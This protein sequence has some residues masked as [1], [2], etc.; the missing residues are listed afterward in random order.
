MSEIVKLSE[1]DDNQVTQAIDVFI[2]GFYNVFNSVTK[3]KAKLH[4]LF[5]HSFDYEMVYTYLHD[6]DVLGFLGLATHQKRPIKLSKAA[7]AEIMS[8]FVGKMAFKS[9]GA[10]I[11]KINVNSPDEVCIDYIATSSEHRSKG[12]GK[13]LIEFVRDNLGYK[14]IKLEVFSKNPRA[15]AFYERIGFTAAGTKSGIMLSLMGHGKTIAMR[16]DVEKSNE[17]SGN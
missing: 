13:K 4:N 17:H 9:M 10:A 5:K 11:E 15:K 7:F 3:D 1:L 2:D 6:G 14:H 8:G 16:M 12:I